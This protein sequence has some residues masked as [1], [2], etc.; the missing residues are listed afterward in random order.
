MFYRPVFSGSFLVVSGVNRAWDKDDGEQKSVSVIAQAMNKNFDEDVVLFVTATKHSSL[1]FEWKLYAFPYVSTLLSI[2]G[3]LGYRT[4]KK[5]GFMMMTYVVRKD[6]SGHS[7]IS[8][9]VPLAKYLWDH[10][11]FQR[12]YE[13]GEVR[14]ELAALAKEYR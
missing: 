11:R 3:R 5:D 2:R 1:G 6:L 12:G 14:A 7:Y 4:M 10:R 9:P 13:R 8:L